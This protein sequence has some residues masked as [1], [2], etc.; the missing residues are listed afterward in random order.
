MLCVPLRGSF[1]CFTHVWRST[2]PL[3]LLHYMMPACGVVEKTAPATGNLVS[4]LSFSSRAG[5]TEASVGAISRYHGN[6]T[7]RLAPGGNTAT[8]CQKANS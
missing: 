3:P 1:L 4:D 5:V 8:L 2:V 7:T 6:K